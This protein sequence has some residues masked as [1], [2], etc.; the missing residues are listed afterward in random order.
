MKTVSPKGK[1]LTLSGKEAKEIGLAE[2]TPV[3]RDEFLRVSG[4]EGKKIK[5]IFPNF[6]E[7]LAGLLTNS[8]VASLLFSLGI[9]GIIF[10]L[11]MPGWGISGTIGVVLLFLFFA[12]KYFGG[13]VEWVDLLLFLL[14]STLLMV[15]I[16]LIPGFGIT[17]IAGIL[18]ILASLYLSLVK[19]PFPRTPVEWHLLREVFYSLSLSGAVL[20]LGFLVFLKYLPRTPLFS[21][22]ALFTSLGK[23]KFSSFPDYSHLA[24]KRGKA[25]SPIRPVGKAEIE[26]KIFDVISE[27]EFIEQGEIVEVVKTE[28]PR[29][30]VRKVAV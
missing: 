4:M 2:G 30:V 10:E 5:E 25:I 3:S 6:G 27:G 15:E 19:H 11:S 16:F 1:L 29:I 13:L 9:L 14:G 22:L 26:E 24:G 17:G 12:G 23:E 20:I 28:G 8:T 18:L 7:R 21:H